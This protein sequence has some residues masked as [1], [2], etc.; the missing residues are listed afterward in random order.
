M[1]SELTSYHALPVT[2]LCAEARFVGV[3]RPKLSLKRVSRRLSLTLRGRQ[4][5]SMSSLAEH[6]TTFEDGGETKANGE[7]TFTYAELVKVPNLCT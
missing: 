6:L 3:F 4:C 2:L 7:L 5:N 1:S